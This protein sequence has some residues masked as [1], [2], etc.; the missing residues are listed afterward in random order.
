[1]G[2]DCISSWSLLIIL[3]CC[4]MLEHIILSS[5]LKH[6][7]NHGIISDSHYG[8]WARRS[9]ETQLV[10]LL[11]DLASSLD[12]GTQTDMVIFDFSKAFDRVN[13]Q[14]LLRKLHHYGI[15]G[16]THQWISSFLLGRSQRLLV[17]GCASNSVPV[18]SGVPQGLV[19]RP[20]LFLLFIN[21]LP[22]KINSRIRLF[23]DDC[24]FIDL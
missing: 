12:R 2:F 3:L 17:E 6:A 9:C 1:M 20:L 19:L 16:S 8:F 13:H 14:R 4:K 10:T 15:R 18:V 23:A 5:I 21:D 11:H 24:I 22:D 7:D